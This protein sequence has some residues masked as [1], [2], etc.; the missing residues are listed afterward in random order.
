MLFTPLLLGIRGNAFIS[1]VSDRNKR[2]LLILVIMSITFDV[3]FCI[4]IFLHV[5]FSQEIVLVFLNSP[6]TFVGHVALKKAM[7]NLGW[8]LTIFDL[9]IPQIRRFRNN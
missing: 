4:M 3:R 8:K 6:V 1:G 2:F 9:T 5:N 7:V